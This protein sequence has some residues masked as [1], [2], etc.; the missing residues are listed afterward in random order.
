MLKYI[1]YI[2]THIDN[3]KIY[4]SIREAIDTAKKEIMILFPIKNLGS[5]AHYLK[6]QI[7]RDRQ[8]RIIYLTQ[9]AYIDRILEETGIQNCRP[10]SIF[11]D[12]KLQLQR[13]TENFEIIN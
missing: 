10:A 5:I 13:I 1:V 3:F 7:E 4:T 6:L 8:A 2:T 12:P 11:M 9:T